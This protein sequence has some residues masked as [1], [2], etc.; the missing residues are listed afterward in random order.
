MIKY[1]NNSFDFQGPRYLD[2]SDRSDRR[3]M[4]KAAS[5]DM[6]TYCQ[7]IK[8]EDGRTKLWG[9]FL[10]AHEFYGPNRNGDAFFEKDLIKRAYTFKKHGMV[11]RN[12][13]NKDPEKA[14]GKVD[15]VTYNP[16]MHRVEGIMNIDN[17]KCQDILEKVANNEDIA[18]SM[19][20]RLKHDICSICKHASKTMD[21][22]C[23][24]L[25]NEM[26]NV[27]PDGRKVYAINPDPIFFDISM[28]W[29]PADPTAYVLKKVAALKPPEMITL[30]EPA[31][32]VNI[33]ASGVRDWTI[34]Q[35]I[36]K[37]SEMEKKIEGIIR[38]DQPP[39][40]AT[41]AMEG[42]VNDDM[43][44][45]ILDRLSGQPLD[46]VLSTLTNS[47]MLLSPREFTIIIR[48]GGELPG[49]LAE[50]PGSFS[51]MDHDDNKCCCG[52]GMPDFSLDKFVPKIFDI[53][54]NFMP[55]RA[56]TDDN[57]QRNVIRISI[58]RPPVSKIIKSDHGVK[59]I[60][61]SGSK[62]IIV[63]KAQQS[64]ARNLSKVYNLYKLGY[65]ARNP[66]PCSC[67]SI[68]ASNYFCSG[69]RN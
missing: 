17:S 39:D 10:G 4:Q 20:A 63:K 36:H 27:Y 40:L 69:E 2:L 15:F 51:R 60:G 30:H 59:I 55:D 58:E 61:G 44:K 5:A 7:N 38:G 3:Y 29:K 65:Y 12:H 49:L 43:P 13:Q 8:P 68:L 25:K 31:P 57:I 19:A 24:H 47:K 23:G 53:V 37:L 34:K 26:N 21:E 18:I 45:E 9:L 11:Y 41:K 32:A 52:D 67:L 64:V 42:C 33:S 66:E 48:K 28:V 6:A 56:I 35:A 54:K 62:E 1:I 22:Y 50:L 46:D 16:G 14:Y